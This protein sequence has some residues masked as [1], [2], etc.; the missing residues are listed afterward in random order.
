[1]RCV[2]CGKISNFLFVIF[3]KW[4]G[5]F[6]CDFFLIKIWWF[7]LAWFFNLCFLP[8]GKFKWKIRE[9]FREFQS[10]FGNELMRT[11]WSNFRWKNYFWTLFQVFL[12]KILGLQNFHS[13][14]I[15]FSSQILLLLSI[16]N[17]SLESR[18]YS[19]SLT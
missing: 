1:M 18:L 12:K 19:A 4:W 10:Y 3:N 16:G 15:N 13:N 8:F 9:R 7:L 5:K 11:F 2:L 6:F 14:F 17:L